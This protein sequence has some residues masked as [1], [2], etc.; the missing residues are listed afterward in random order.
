MRPHQR[1][2][3]LDFRVSRRVDIDNIGFLLHLH[4][5]RHLEKNKLVQDRFFGG[6]VRVKEMEVRVEV[7]VTLV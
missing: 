6:R 4:S 7:R 1:V 3:S 2:E 5:H